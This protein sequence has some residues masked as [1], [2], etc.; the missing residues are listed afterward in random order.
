MLQKDP[1]IDK[2]V[3]NGI[4]TES[5]TVLQQTIEVDLRINGVLQVLTNG[6]LAEP[7][8]ENDRSEDEV[9]VDDYRDVDEDPVVIDDDDDDDD[10][11]DFPTDYED[12]DYDSDF[13][14]W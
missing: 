12:A 14:N 7:P 3:S 9:Y 8:E 10:D 5:D 13:S 11:D 6:V 4:I 1:I 2:S